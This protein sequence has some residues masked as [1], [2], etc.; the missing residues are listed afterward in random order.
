M[1]SSEVSSVILY[2][3]EMIL[4]HQKPLS[5]D[6]EPAR[7]MFELLIRFLDHHQSETITV[8]LLATLKTFILKYAPAIFKEGTT[9]CGELCR[10]ALKYACSYLSSVRQ[11]AAAVLYLLMKKNF[12]ASNGNGFLKVRVKFS[13]V[14]IV[15]NYFLQVRTQLTVALDRLTVTTDSFIRRTLATVIAYSS[16]DT[17]LGRSPFPGQVKESV[18]KMIQLNRD[19]IRMNEAS[20]DP[21]L[22]IDMNF[23]VAMGRL[24]TPDLRLTSLDKI[25]KRNLNNEDYQ[26]AA[27]CLLHQAA[28]IAECMHNMKRRGI[29]TSVNEGLATGAKEF[30]TLSPNMAMEQRVS[31]VRFCW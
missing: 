24:N 4:S 10:V 23:R 21:D 5:H 14:S 26:E 1:L 12:E 22:F 30:M 16:A 6:S 31:T 17:S 9:Y 7:K 25:L 29:L 3:F 20:D 11:L 27:Y 28:L 8:Q 2:V 18:E 19:S 13:F 15:L